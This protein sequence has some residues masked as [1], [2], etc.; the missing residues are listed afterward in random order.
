MAGSKGPGEGPSPEE[1]ERVLAGL[2]MT[3]SPVQWAVVLEFVT[4]K[5][6]EAHRRVEARQTAPSGTVN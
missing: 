5:V 6:M 4:H 3:L 1:K 2:I